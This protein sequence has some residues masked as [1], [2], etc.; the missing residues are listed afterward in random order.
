MSD[1]EQEQD[2]ICVLCMLPIQHEMFPNGGYMGNNPVPLAPAGTRCCDWCNSLKVTPARLGLTGD[3]AE[4]LGRTFVR[5]H[6][7]QMHEMKQHY[8]KE[9]IPEGASE[10]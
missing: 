7:I 2:L 10:K 8:T 6:A 5:I 1:E 9:E 4:E 3:A